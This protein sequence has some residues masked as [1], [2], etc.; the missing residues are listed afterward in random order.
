MGSDFIGLLPLI[1]KFMEVKKYSAKHK[2]QV[3]EILDFLMSRAKG[4]VPTGARFIR[5]YIA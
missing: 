1:R 5:N 4:E 3:E 2:E